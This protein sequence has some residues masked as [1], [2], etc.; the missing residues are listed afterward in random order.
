MT[1]KGQISKIRGCILGAVLGDAIGGPFE[2][3]PVERAAAQIGQPW[4]DGLYPYE[5]APSPHGVWGAQ[6][7]AGT[8][9]DDTR[10]NWLFLELAVEL[11]R[12]PTGRDLAGRFL[13]I[14]RESEALFPGY[15]AL[16]RKQFAHWEGVC[17]GYLGQASDLY[18]GLPPDVLLAR[19]LGLNFPI[20]SGLIT[21]TS[22]GLLFPGRPEDAY[23]AA[24]RAAFYDIG[25]AREAVALLSAAIS[26]APGLP[27][28]DRIR[29]RYRSTAPSPLS[30]SAGR[31]K[32]RRGQ[33][34]RIGRRRTQFTLGEAS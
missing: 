31:H 13:E 11:G 7:P 19:S 5:I 28:T 25:Y 17:R 4:I 34:A 33:P 30:T 27:A 29:Q 2:F 32:A 22:A 12:M 6:P 14:Y 20:L 15:G 26:M 8:G 18:P 21:L 16:A 24:F 1:S 10:Y 23:Q 3:G 9:T